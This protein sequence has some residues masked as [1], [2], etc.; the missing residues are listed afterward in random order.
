[1]V[2][3]NTD[4]KLIYIFFEDL[5]SEELINRTGN[6]VGSFDHI[7]NSDIDEFHPKLPYL[8]EE[9]KTFIIKVFN[10]VKETLI[11]SIIVKNEKF[12]VINAIIIFFNK[13]NKQYNDK[14]DVCKI[15]QSNEENNSIVNKVSRYW[16]CFLM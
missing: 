7:L 3:K 8:I 14:L 10:K 16:I 2:M 6:Y 1:M 5:L 11:N 4:Y 13:Y 12:S 15:I 9:Y